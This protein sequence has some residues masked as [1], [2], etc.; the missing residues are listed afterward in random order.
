M[1]IVLLESLGIRTEELK[2]HV[3]ELEKEGHI[4]MAY[5]RDLDSQ[6][7]IER[8]KEAE[9]LMIANMP[10]K[11]EVVE[12]CD[13]LRFINVAFTGVDHIPVAF[14]K[15]R[16]I[17]VSNASGYS[18]ESVAELVL[19]MTLSL[20]RKVPTVDKETRKGGVVGK[21]VGN[22]LRGRTVGVIGSG[23][24]GTRVAELFNSFGCRVLAYDVVPRN[25][26]NVKN[27]TLE[28]LLRTSDIVTLHCP[29]MES[30]IKL[31]NE[32]TIGMMKDGA[33]LINASRGPVVDMDALAKALNNHK[34][35]AAGIDVYEIEPPLPE[36][37]PLISAENTILTPHIAYLSEESMQ[38]RAEIVFRSLHEW[39]KGNQINKIV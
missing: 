25:L 10:L 37:H 1:K 26:P 38:K 15:E 17:A 24:I 16:G 2:K 35:A 5:E 34:L 32:K 27:V 20:L 21:H 22:E 9:V 30:T 36:N 33:I 23:A 3:A 7:Q 39:L 12:A 6:K 28:D 13:K 11:K 29:L 18:N 14:A 19:G 8:L 4:F 31:I